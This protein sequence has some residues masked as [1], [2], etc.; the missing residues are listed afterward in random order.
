M[1]LALFISSAA[2]TIMLAITQPYVLQYSRDQSLEFGVPS[3]NIFGWDL[4][5]EFPLSL[6]FEPNPAMHYLGE[7][8][9]RKKKKTTNF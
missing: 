2:P 3:C 1:T 5:S 8:K 9:R 7:K 6:A 4:I